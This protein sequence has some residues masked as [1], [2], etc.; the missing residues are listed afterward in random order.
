ME[1]SRQ[2]YSSERKLIRRDMKSF[3][4]LVPDVFLS[5]I[6]MMAALFLIYFFKNYIG[7]LSNLGAQK[8]LEA[9]GTSQALGGSDTTVQITSATK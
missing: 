4:K 5:S 6:C 1:P 2:D 3:L 7:T 9:M 8:T